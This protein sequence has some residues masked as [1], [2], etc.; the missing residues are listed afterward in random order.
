MKTL[1]LGRESLRHMIVSE[2][3]FLCQQRLTSNTVMSML[4]QMGPLTI[5]CMPLAKMQTFRLA[6][7]LLLMG[8]NQ[9]LICQCG[10]AVHLPNSSCVWTMSC[11]FTSA[12]GLHWTLCQICDPQWPKNSSFFPA[13]G[14]YVINTETLASLSVSQLW[15]PKAF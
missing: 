2:I 15:L 6:Q 12:S 1:W 14:L 3:W 13:A 10:S 7:S 4:P 11:H 9:Q 8:V 5:W